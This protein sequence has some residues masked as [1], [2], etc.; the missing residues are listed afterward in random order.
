MGLD[1]NKIANQ[2]HCSQKEA[3]QRLKEDALLRAQ[4]QVTEQE[5]KEL[6]ELNGGANW[7][8]TMD[9][10]AFNSTKAKTYKAELPQAKKENKLAQARRKN[11]EE[12]SIWKKIGKYAGAGL[13]VAGTGVVI[14]AAAGAVAAT[15][16]G[17]A[18]AGVIGAGALLFTSCS[19]DINVDQTA[20]TNITIPKAKDYSNEI[21][22]IINRLN[23]IDDNNAKA[24]LAILQ[25]LDNIINGQYT[26]QQNLEA[27]LLTMFTEIRTWLEKI[28][29]NQVNMQ[30]DNNQNAQDIL[31]KL[32][33]ILASNKTMAE[34]LEE[35]IKLLGQIK[36]VGEDILAAIK[37]AKQEIIN[38]LNTNNKAVIDAINKLDE[39]DQK[40]LQLLNDIKAL[41]AKY[42][43]NN[44][45][46][47]QAI[48][49][50]IGKM[51]N[52]VDLS[53]IEA[54]LAQLV[55]GQKQTNEG[56]ANLTAIFERFS[57]DMVAKLNV[58]ISKLDKNSPDYSAQLN[59]I[60]ELLEKMDANNEARNKKILDAIDKLGA[61][62]SGSLTAILNAIKELPN[63]KD[64][65]SILNAILAKLGNIDANN[66][67]NFQKV[68]DALAELGSGK[69]IDVD[70]QPI[71]NKLQEILEAIKDHKVT[72]DITG[73]V[74]CECN[75]G[76]SGTH[77]GIIGDLNDLLG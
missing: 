54:L 47:A 21:K 59:A 5:L 26:N 24:Y 11:N 76:N 71:L 41:I 32:N 13:A 2:M 52:N 55:N 4:Y 74:T 72:V 63:G 46:L 68:L 14:A 23:S 69:T 65:E 25:K 39:N 22:E 42:G 77:E 16:P 28:V 30:A 61:K 36:S 66:S 40:T 62:I 58:I 51:G 75:C 73:K 29:Q 20:I 49:V 48:L 10:Y 67:I 7:G 3:I 6:E 15:L 17:W 9:E 44:N 45:A 70:L 33:E 53:G 19:S 31:N 1:I 18:I 64:Y 27:T 50:A 37:N 12:P 56:I 35:I 38:T 8:K 57:A 34:K 43:E 60:I